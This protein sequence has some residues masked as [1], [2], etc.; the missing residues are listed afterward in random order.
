MAIEEDIHEVQ[1]SG[2][3]DK[4]EELAKDKLVHIP[5]VGSDGSEAL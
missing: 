1:L 5:I 4:I 2:N 3:V